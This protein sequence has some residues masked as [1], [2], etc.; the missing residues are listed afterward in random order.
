MFDCI[1]P[2]LVET[3]QLIRIAKLSNFEKITSSTYKEASGLEVGRGSG[4]RVWVP[5]ESF[6]PVI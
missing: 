4:W 1:H 3:Q 2:N 6:A 5:T